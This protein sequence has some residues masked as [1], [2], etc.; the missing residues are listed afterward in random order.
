MVRVASVAN[1]LRSLHAASRIGGHASIVSAGGLEA[2]A[3]RAAT[4]ASILATLA[5]FACGSASAVNTLL[6]ELALERRQCWERQRLRRRFSL[7]LA[8]R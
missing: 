5:T 7:S 4:P 6:C 8:A 3:A 1:T 2:A